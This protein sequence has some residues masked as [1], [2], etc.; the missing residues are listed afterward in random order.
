MWKWLD[1][2]CGCHHRVGSFDT[3]ERAAHAL[4]TGFWVTIWGEGVTTHLHADHDHNVFAQVQW[5][6]S[7]FVHSEPDRLLH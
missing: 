5:S 1:A 3:V 2:T 6:V 7:L 4:I